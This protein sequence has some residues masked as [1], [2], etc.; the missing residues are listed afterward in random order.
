[1]P[2]STF[3]IKSK[4]LSTELE[5]LGN[6]GPLALSLT[7]P[8][9]SSR[10]PQAFAHT[11]SFIWNALPPLFTHALRLIPVTSPRMPFQLPTLPHTHI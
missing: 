7:I 9:W 10:A 8:H 5:A 6:L 1:M 3:Q 2:P 4:L 11:A